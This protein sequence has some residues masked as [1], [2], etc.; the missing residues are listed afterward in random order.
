MFFFPTYK[1]LT[2]KF[3]PPHA[4]KIVKIVI[5]KIVKFI[6]LKREVSGALNRNNNIIYY[7]FYSV[8]FSR[9]LREANLT[10]L[11]MT[12]LTTSHSSNA[13]TPRCH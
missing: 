9:Q 5:V 4:V 13:R 3:N 1:L 6:F 7:Y 8:R 2:R 11:T 12:I 10:I